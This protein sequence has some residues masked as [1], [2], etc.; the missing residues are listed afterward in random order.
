MADSH[1]CPLQTQTTLHHCNMDKV[2]EE[3]MSWQGTR[4]GMNQASKGNVADCCGFTFKTFQN[5]GLQ[6]HFP[7]RVSPLTF[8]E[9]APELVIN[10][11]L[12]HFKETDSPK[13]GDLVLFSSPR[14]GWCAGVFCHGSYYSIFPDKGLSSI[15]IKSR[16]NFRY[17]THIKG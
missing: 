13:D 10:D 4:F 17:Y 1:L 7:L 2:K 12:V 3:I 8:A 5:L 11:T 14:H 9:N 15:V 16:K 6:E